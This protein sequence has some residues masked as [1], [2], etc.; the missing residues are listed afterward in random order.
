MR[1]DSWHVLKVKTGTETE[2]AR[3]VSAPSYVPHQLV[4]AFNRRQRRVVVRQK[5]AFPG[6]VFVQ[7]EAPQTIRL[8]KGAYGF[9]RNENRS[10]ACLHPKEFQSIVRFEKEVLQHLPEKTK[11]TVPSITVGSA[12]HFVT[13]HALEKFSAVV[14]EI[15]HNRL[16]LGVFGGKFDVEA[17]PSA[18]S[19]A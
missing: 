7:S 18:V 13:G 10:F 3:A 12:V 14:K 2:V 15:R 19:L 16:L 6:Y 1:S 9:M 5:V 8:P 17:P 4:S 11:T